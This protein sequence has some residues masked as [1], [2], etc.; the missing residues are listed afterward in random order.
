[1]D[2]VPLLSVEMVDKLVQV[3]TRSIGLKE[4]MSVTSIKFDFLEIIYRCKH[5]FHL[6]YVIEESVKF[7]HHSSYDIRVISVTLVRNILADKEH[8]KNPIPS[9]LLILLCEESLPFL[10]FAS[11]Q[12]SS[13][14][15]FAR[16]LSL[17]VVHC[18]K[19]LLDYPSISEW[20]IHFLPA[21]EWMKKLQGILQEFQVRW[22]HLSTN[23]VKSAVAASNSDDIRAV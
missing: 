9:S 15:I 6:D 7:F 12:N 18:F 14:V 5:E 22:N 21:R 2:L 16:I 20:A 3:H 1:V 11:L 23:E 13:E 19:Q 4:S 8:L 17:C 10:P